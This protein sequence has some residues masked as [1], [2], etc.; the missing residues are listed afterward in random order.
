MDF[1]FENIK[2]KKLLQRD[3]PLNIPRYQREYS[4]E[5][6]EIQ[7]FLN[8]ILSE[9]VVDE[10]KLLDHKEYF[11]GTIL[12]GHNL[13]RKYVEIID[14]QQRITT[15]T[16]FLSVLSKIFYT[17]KQ[18]VLGDRI[19]EYIMNKDDDGNE[20][21]TLENDTTN[22]YFEYLI[23]TKYDSS[24]NFLTKEKDPMDEEQ[25][26]IKY[27]YE[28]FSKEL[29]EENIKNRIEKVN[30][31]I[32][33]IKNRDYLEILK[34]IRTQLLESIIICISAKDN[35]SVNLIFE[36]LN[37]KGKKLE[38]I[39]LI[40]NSV[41]SHL[42]KDNPTDYANNIWKE[43][44]KTLNS[45]KNRVEFST[46]FRHYW[47]ARYKKV[48]DDQIYKE[49]TNKVDK[50]EYAAFLN[51]LKEMANTYV[52]IISPLE[53]DYDHH[54]NL[55]C[56]TKNLKYLNEY[57][58]IKQIRVILL[59]LFDAKFNKDKISSKKLIDIVTYLHQFHFVFN[60][61]CTR[62]GNTFENL[63]SKYAI[64][65][66]NQ[67][68]K[69]NVH[70]IIDE[71]KKELDKKFP[72]YNDFEKEFTKLEF[73]KKKNKTNMISKYV[74]YNIEYYYSNTY[75]NNSSI[76]HILSEDDNKPYTLNI[77][78]LVLLE[79]HLNSVAQDKEINEKINLY[80]QSVH[81][82]PKKFIEN[83]G[84]V[85]TWNEDMIRNRTKALSQLYYEK[86]LNKKIQ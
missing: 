24:Y 5:E 81:K 20:F 31:N 79:N 15:I 82:S 45:R 17:N 38:A 66:F 14:G 43:I 58:K 72:N 21:K 42:N 83:N 7:E 68:D 70:I 6:K 52:K 1:N 77:G 3:V 86:I 27:A 48:K 49:F 50:K 41:F 59:A 29:E 37:A 12:L 23:Q 39:D 47:I 10:N 64:K 61:L 84:Q 75:F 4:W 46:F 40:K 33:N 67:K 60:A 35:R 53:S 25:E 56:M 78:N 36:I 85:N 22:D 34:A 18:D 57:F 65:I 26:K 44:K 71:L 11:F 63:Y 8:D 74:L 13:K 2:I 9:I 80:K 51:E 55:K 54:T 76:E 73:S 30:K 19:W 16:I 28:Y 62:R 32:N 69:E